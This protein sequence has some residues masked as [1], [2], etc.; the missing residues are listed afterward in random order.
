MLTISDRVDVPIAKVFESLKKDLI[1]ADK[2]SFS[3]DDDPEVRDM[4]CKV[5][6]EEDDGVDSDDQNVVE[7]QTKDAGVNMV[8]VQLLEVG[9]SEKNI[10]VEGGLCGGR[11]NEVMFDSEKIL[12]VEGSEPVDIGCSVSESEAVGVVKRCRGRLKK[13]ALGHKSHTSTLKSSTGAVTHNK[14]LPSVHNS[15]AILSNEED[16]MEC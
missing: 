3:W 16:H 15:F 14:S 2:Q 7:M 5:F 12:T 4:L 1:V 9:D 11:S 13:S 10:A 8:D 6:H